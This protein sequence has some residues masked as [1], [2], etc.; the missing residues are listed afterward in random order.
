MLGVLDAGTRPA[1]KTAD[2]VMHSDPARQGD[3][4]AR[5]RR[6]STETPP[7]LTAQQKQS[8][9]G[10]KVT[11]TLLSPKVPSPSAS[12]AIQPRATLPCRPLPVTQ[13]LPTR[14]T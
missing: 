5:A 12:H 4:M 6:Y 7:R 13:I 11:E 14:H 3:D 10:K 8:L 9:S 2:N 1:A